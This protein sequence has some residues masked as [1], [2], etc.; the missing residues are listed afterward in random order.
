MSSPLRR[1]NAYRLKFCG[2]RKCNVRIARGMTEHLPGSRRTQVPRADAGYA[3]RA[4]R[5]QSN[6]A[7]VFPFERSDRLVDRS[8]VEQLR[9]RFLAVSKD[10]TSFANLT[11]GWANRGK[12]YKVT[13]SE[14]VRAPLAGAADDE[15]RKGRLRDTQDGSHAQSLGSM[16]DEAE[17]VYHRQHDHA[18]IAATL[19]HNGRFYS[20]RRSQRRSSSGNRLSCLFSTNPLFTHGT[21]C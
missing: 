17:A 18:A 6:P 4:H 19:K 1:K 9:D 8:P 11:T 21:L 15:A 20:E 12:A 2:E 3:A 14:P 16:A 13:A 10:Y 7:S 5:G